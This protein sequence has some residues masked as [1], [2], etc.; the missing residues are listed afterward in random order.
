MQTQTL[1]K[2][3][4][5]DAMREVVQ[6]HHQKKVSNLEAIARYQAQLRVNRLNNSAPQG[7]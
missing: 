7:N 3:F 4:Q 6:T 5:H 2:F 1:P